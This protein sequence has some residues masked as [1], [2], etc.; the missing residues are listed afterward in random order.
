MASKG[1]GNGRRKK[2]PD[3]LPVGQY[4]PPPPPSKGIKNG[5]KECP[6]IDVYEETNR[7][8]NKDGT[9]GDWVETRAK[10]TYEEFQKS[11]EEWRQTQLRGR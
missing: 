2:G 4:T 9:R 3:N 6:F 10:N 5:R 7:K 11:I 8:K 1:H